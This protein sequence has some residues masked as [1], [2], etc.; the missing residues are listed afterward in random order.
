MRIMKEAF[1]A[2]PDELKTEIQNRYR[3]SFSALRADLAQAS[4]AEALKYL[5]MFQENDTVILVIKNGG[6]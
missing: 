2:N 1:F 5:V 3:V 6:L 4:F